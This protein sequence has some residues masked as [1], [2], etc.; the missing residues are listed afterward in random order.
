MKTNRLARRLGKFRGIL[1][2]LALVALMA[3]EFWLCES[4]ATH[5]GQNTALRTDSL[6][7][8]SVGLSDLM[9]A[10]R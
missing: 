9:V 10:A 7:A 4:S 5:I 6:Q 3:T 1:V 8:P 2:C